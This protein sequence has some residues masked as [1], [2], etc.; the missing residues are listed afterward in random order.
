MAFLTIPDYKYQLDEQ[1]QE[2]LF[3]DPQSRIKAEAA[4]IEEMA[5]YLRG[6]FDTVALFALRGNARN[7]L[8]VM[9]LVDMSIY[10]LF[11]QL[12]MAELPKHRKDRYQA[13][14]AWLVDVADGKSNPVL[15]EYAE[16]EDESGI[17]FGSEPKNSNFY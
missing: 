11:T 14:V 3:Y 17:K 4:A 8:I 1:A 15:P 12:E 7:Q 5:S 2:E 6:R 9:Y 10:H 16:P 13:A